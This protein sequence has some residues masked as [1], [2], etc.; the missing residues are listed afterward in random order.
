MKNEIIIDNGQ[1]IVCMAPAREGAG[2]RTPAVY[3]HDLLP[4]GTVVIL[5]GSTLPED[6]DGARAFCASRYLETSEAVV[7]NVIFYD[8]T[9]P[10]TR[11]FP[12]REGEETVY[13]YLTEEDADR[14]RRYFS[15][16]YTMKF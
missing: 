10:H 1:Y 3:R 11:K 5:R 12:F 9:S 6:E 7:G 16:D 14:V 4:G 13:R 2:G 8:G 15:S